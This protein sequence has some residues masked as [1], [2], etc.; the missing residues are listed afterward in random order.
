VAKRLGKLLDDLGIR[1]VLMDVGASGGPPAIWTDIAP[2]STYIGFDPDLR[3]IHEDKS[4]GFYRSVILNEAVTA[5]KN[6]S[7]IDFFLTRSP[8]CSTTLA[9][10]PPAAAHWLERDC[11][12]VEGRATV[13][14]TT[15]DS[16]LTR[17][18]IPRLDWIK[19]DTQ[20]TDRRLINSLCPH[21][22][23]RLMAI[24][25]EPGLV[26]IYQCE[27]LFVDVHRDLTRKG[28]W[29]SSMHTDGLIRMRR[30]TLGIL[31]QVNPKIDDCY[32]RSATNVSP[33][34][35]EARYLRTLEWLVDH[36]MTQQEY[37]LLWI[38][39][40]VDGQFG[41]ALDV[42]VEFDRIFGETEA[43]EQLKAVTWLLMSRVH[44]RRTLK[45]ASAPVARRVRSVLGLLID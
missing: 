25:T 2:Y 36:S 31:R 10:N 16:V 4:S 32:I 20:G 7:E 11:F 3:E 19:L 21:V 24:D 9:P 26:E 37:M 40:L 18:N 39:A 42:S 27:D 6:A 12:A 23:T 13:R 44:R 1:P 15:I 41:F 28:F 30:E 22:F 17:L 29:L 43:S 5:D 33:A 38:F 8:Y 35:H 45:S 14:A 34:Y